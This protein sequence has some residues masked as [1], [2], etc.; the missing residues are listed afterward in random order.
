VE[1]ELLV[2]AVKIGSAVTVGKKGVT[3]ENGVSRKVADG[4]PR[5]SGRIRHNEA[6]SAEDERIRILYDSRLGV[7]NDS[8]SAEEDR[9]SVFRAIGEKLL[10][11]RVN[12]NGNLLYFNQRV[13]GADVVKVSVRQQD[14][15]QGVALFIQKRS[16]LFAVAIGIDQNG[17]VRILINNEIGI[18][19]KDA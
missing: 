9:G 1:N 14:R 17:F 11:L 13:H 12:V 15:L 4:A 16:D 5:M 6:K 3:R 8:L 18:G 7:A 10:I 19:S 2:A